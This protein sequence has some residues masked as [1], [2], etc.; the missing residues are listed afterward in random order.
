MYFSDMYSN[1]PSIR[2]Q[3]CQYPQPKRRSKVLKNESASNVNSPQGLY[4]ASFISIDDS[5]YSSELA[6]DVNQYSFTGEERMPPQKDVYSHFPTHRYHGNSSAHVDSQIVPPVRRPLF[7]SI[8]NI[9]RPCV[10][11]STVRSANYEDKLKRSS[12][13]PQ[14][15]TREH[16]ANILKKRNEKKTHC[17]YP[18]SNQNPDNNTSHL[19]KPTVNPE[20]VSNVSFDHS[21]QTSQFQPNIQHENDQKHIYANLYRSTFETN[22]ASFVNHLYGE[23][24]IQSKNDLSNDKH[25]QERNIPPFTH[26]ER[27]YSNIKIVNTVANN[28]HSYENYP[29][30]IKTSESTLVDVIPRDVFEVKE[31]QSQDLSVSSQVEKEEKENY[32]TKNLVRG[33]SETR[34]LENQVFHEEESL[35][36]LSLENRSSS[37][38]NS[39]KK[40]LSR[41][42]SLM[43]RSSKRYFYNGP[44][45]NPSICMADLLSAK[46]N[47]LPFGS[48]VN[49]KDCIAN[50]IQEAYQL[51]ELNKVETLNRKQKLLNILKSKSSSEKRNSKLALPKD[52]KKKLKRQR[53]LAALSVACEDEDYGFAG[54]N[55]DVKNADDD[56]LWPISPSEEELRTKNSNSLPS[57]FFEPLETS[58]RKE[59]LNNDGVQ[60]VNPKTRS[61]LKIS[62]SRSKKRIISTLFSRG[63]QKCECDGTSR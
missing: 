61:F 39:K 57:T 45:R 59:I 24:F 41:C 16:L 15:L 13:I 44:T 17:A 10:M 50:L 35:L 9:S 52:S 22:C 49:S 4:R 48:M 36:T 30:L 12:N 63:S 8:D 46:L 2:I 25:Y 38:R 58:S 5:G 6:N 56:S 11:Q 62:I 53:S 23:E 3:K 27:V 47:I 34:Q 32:A 40:D 20:F 42:S 55:S 43:Y 31:E 26:N 37:S 14:R 51:K 33:R 21:L 7:Q 29:D 19:Y 28:L 60:F 1:D 54:W 18:S